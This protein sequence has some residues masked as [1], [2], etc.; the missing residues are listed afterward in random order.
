MIR[1]NKVFTEDEYALVK[2][3]IDELDWRFVPQTEYPLA[4][5][6][7]FSQDIK[8]AQNPKLNTYWL[9][10]LLATKIE[11]Y[12]N[13]QHFLRIKANLLTPIDMEYKGTP[14]VD[15]DI[16]HHVGIFYFSTEK[17]GIGQTYLFNERVDFE[18]GVN[19]PDRLSIQHTI[20]CKENTA[21]FFEG[22]RL[23]CGTHPK[24]I[25]TRIVLN[26]NFIGTPN[27]KQT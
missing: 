23:H 1:D 13:I 14:H 12:Y 25:Y 3:Y 10:K 19:I 7:G 20:P 24:N 27:G 6:P 9:N 21:V 17:P 8:I 22:N 4:S 15:A 18:Q 5:P 2:N 11:K 26:V 16:D